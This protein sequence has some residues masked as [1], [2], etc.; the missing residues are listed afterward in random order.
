MSK[1][2][3][4]DRINSAIQANN[5]TEGLIPMGKGPIPTPARTYLSPTDSYEDEIG[6]DS[7]TNS[8]HGGSMRNMWALADQQNASVPVTVLKSSGNTKSSGLASIQGGL[9][10]NPVAPATTWSSVPQL[11]TNLTTKG[12]VLIQGGVSVRSSAATDSIGVA[13]YRDGNLIGNHVT[14]T[15]PST[16]SAVSLVNLSTMDNPPPGL[17]VYSLQWSPGTGTLTAHSNQRNLNVINLFPQ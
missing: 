3:L 8:F 9:V 5:T 2:S 6:F 1:P 4:T 13:I 16:V 17:H 10:L 11:I 12:P 7:G 15:T 14:H